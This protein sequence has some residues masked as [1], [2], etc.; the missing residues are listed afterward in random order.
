MFNQSYTLLID[1]LSVSRSG[2]HC[3]FEYWPTVLPVSE[4]QK[5]AKKSAYQLLK[6]SVG[7]RVVRNM[8]TKWSM[9]QISKPNVANVK[10]I[11]NKLFLTFLVIMTVLVVLYVVNSISTL[12]QQKHNKI[13][14]DL[15]QADA[16][17]ENSLKYQTDAMLMVLKGIVS[18]DEMMSLFYQRDKGQLLASVSELYTE[19]NQ[20]IKVTHLYFNGP[21]RVNFLRVHSPNKNGDRIDRITTIN[22]QR[23]G[24]VSSGMELGQSGTLTLRLVMPIYQDDL[25][26]GFLEIGMEVGHLLEDVS[27][28][29]GV[30]A[31]I[32]LD[33]SKIN[34]KQA[35]QTAL[36]EETSFAELGEYLLISKVTTNPS[37]KFTPLI[38]R[39][40]THGG[41]QIETQSFSDGMV[42]SGNLIALNDVKGSIGKLI[43]LS[44]ITE[45]QRYTSEKEW[46]Y[47]LVVVTLT[48]L[49]TIFFYRVAKKV[50]SD[51][52]VVYDN[53][54]SSLLQRSEQL[55]VSEEKLKVAQQITKLGYWEL[56]Y[57]NPGSIEEAMNTNRMHW[58]DEIY[59]IF[60][61]DK[62][63][64]EVTLAGTV[65][66]FYEDD[67]ERVSNLLRKAIA[68]QKDF[69]AIHRI[70]S[71]GGQ[72]KWVDARCSTRFS[73]DGVP[74]VTQGTVQDITSLKHAELN[75][76]SSEQR[77]KTI[78]D[79]ATDGIVLIDG[80]GVVRRNN[81]AFEKMFGLT[82]K[83]LIGR[84]IKHFL[85]SGIDELLEIENTLLL[86][87]SENDGNAIE[88]QVH[89]SEDIVLPVRLG[90]AKVKI[91]D[92]PFFIGSFTNLTDIKRLEAQVRHAQKMDAI[93]ELSGGIAHDFNNILGIIIG[94]LDLLK[95]TLDKEDK[96]YSRIHKA[97]EA[98]LRGA[99]LTRKLLNFSRQSADAVSPVNLNQV[100]R[101]IQE[102]L[103]KSL[104]SRI[105]IDMLLEE[106]LW[107]AE[108]DP[109]GFEDAIINLTINA[110]DAMPDG[111]QITIST[112]NKVIERSALQRL[113]NAKLGEFVEVVLSDNGVGISQN[114]IDKIYDPFFTTKKEGKGTGLG[115][116]M[117]YG[118][119]ERC[120]GFV[121][122]NSE[123]GVG[124][125]FR[126]YFPKSQ[127]ALA[128]LQADEAASPEEIPTGSETILI[129]DDEPEL[130]QL[131]NDILSQLGYKTDVVFS[132][133]D[134]LNYLAQ[135]P[136]TE[137][138]FSD[139]VMPGVD[140]FGLAA[141]ID[142]NY[143]EVKVL[144]TSGYT[145]KI[146]H[147]ESQKRY[148]NRVLTKPYRKIELAN[149]I[150]RVLDE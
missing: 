18:N 37:G 121:Q 85:A 110:R 101:N 118:Y 102:L 49:V 111:G 16:W 67:R 46:Q 104:T 10:N 43:V 147:L 95:V 123:V 92:Q 105:T 131:A 7:L 69:H 2:Y 29:L 24:A 107:L 97:Q 108:L 82:E 47:I 8:D 25:M 41:A 149:N 64:F 53:L 86:A 119:V 122:V 71:G 13:T 133:D 65:E 68:E 150:R 44:D 79:N 60:G 45:L 70:V 134:A 103:A 89:T 15:T 126:L 84:E 129:V 98:A 99:K 12:Q 109:F 20:R 81:R 9:E 61:V 125:T 6:I 34:L 113:P 1:V 80:N 87:Q 106:S 77:M 27:E 76:V 91:E 120:G 73:A 114:I 117:V 146:T 124:S 96:H 142:K 62:L 66:A 148:E 40:L 90:V 21:D 23:T 137:L 39:L 4:L 52:D 50:Q 83:E 138:V 42:Y 74:I 72:I 88:I 59:R 112:N 26:S 11:R 55:S 51:V 130:A 14:R 54:I 128:K 32:A 30:R 75:A 19:L 93:G 132:A 94:Q 63:N 139:V 3:T 116:S 100:L 127:Q 144:L 143:P 5:C 140:G 22:A 57:E 58:S 141:E 135:N 33:K 35:Q 145:G 48:I 38:K 136:D 78:F 36:D 56:H 31:L 17:F 115:L 28:T